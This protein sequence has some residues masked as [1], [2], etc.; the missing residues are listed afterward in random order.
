MI[1]ADGSFIDLEK[2]NNGELKWIAVSR[3]LRSEFHYGDTVILTGGIEGEFVVRDTMN[4]KWKSRVDILSPIGDSKGKWID[5]CMFKK[6]N[7]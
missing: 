7:N 6:E 5:V 4:P 3:D 1:T 2:L